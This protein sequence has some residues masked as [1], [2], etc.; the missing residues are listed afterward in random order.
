MP[1][2]ELVHKHT[3]NLYEGDFERLQE[4]YPE[5]GAGIVVRKL[6]RKHLHSIEQNLTPINLAGLEPDL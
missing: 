4:M 2:R 1:E 3:I 5:L 6:V